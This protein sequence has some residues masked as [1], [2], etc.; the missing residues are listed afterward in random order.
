MS[1]RPILSSLRHHKLTA[2]LLVLQVALTLAIVANAAF[3]VAQRVQRIR[4]PSGLAEKELSLIRVEGTVK[5]ENH[6]ARQ[7]ADLDALRRIP[8]VKAAVVVGWALP[9]SSN[10]NSYG[11]CPARRRSSAPWRQTASTT[12]VACRSTPTVAVPGSLQRSD[13]A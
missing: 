11:I 7:A 4:T 3:M 6:Q 2:G 10:V 5:D 9:F 13:C 12:P 8:G 1:L